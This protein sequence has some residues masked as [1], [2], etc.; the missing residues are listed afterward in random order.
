MSVRL[1]AIRN[2]RYRTTD[3]GVPFAA[4]TRHLFTETSG[5]ALEPVQIHVESILRPL[6]MEYKA[7]GAWGLIKHTDSHF[8]CHEREMTPRWWIMYRH[9]TVVRTVNE[10]NKHGTLL[11]AVPLQAWSGPEGYR[12][13]RFPD[14]VTTAQN[15]GKFVSLTHRP[16]L[17]PGNTPGTHFC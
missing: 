15:G 9:Y 14:F 6:W 4:G 16:H 8:C 3:E 2:V 7:V 17:P 12:K 1:S 13:L 10:H 11:K 5:L